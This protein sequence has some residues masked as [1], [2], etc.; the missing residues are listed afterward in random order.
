M[1]NVVL[2]IYFN[3]N[4]IITT[5]EKKSSE[6]YGNEVQDQINLFFES[7]E[8]RSTGDTVSFCRDELNKIVTD[9][10]FNNRQIKNLL[11]NY[12]GEGVCFTYPCD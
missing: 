2:D 3:I 4:A 6:D 7:L 10:N 9:I 8:L 11:I 1:Q 5:T 12:F